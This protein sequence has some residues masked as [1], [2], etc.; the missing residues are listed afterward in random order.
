MKRKIAK[1]VTLKVHIYKIIMESLR[2][3]L[4]NLFVSIRRGLTLVTN[5]FSQFKD[6]IIGWFQSGDNGDQQN[7][8]DEN[9]ELNTYQ[10]AADFLS[11]LLDDSD[12]DKDILGPNHNQD[13][14]ILELMEDSDDQ[15][16]D[17]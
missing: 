10:S 14:P 13:Q 2:E 8:D 4:N 15:S 17:E 11:E 6:N 1:I 16:S 5:A 3:L 7:S 9:E 12:D